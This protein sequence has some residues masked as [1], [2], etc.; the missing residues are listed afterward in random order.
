[1]KDFRILLVEGSPEEEE[2]IA[3]ISKREKYALHGS[4]SYR[5]AIDS[6]RDNDFDL[7]LIRCRQDPGAVQEVC[8]SIRGEAGEDPTQIIF[9]GDSD[10]HAE[11][12]FIECAHDFILVPV[13]E[14][15][16]AVR[17]RNAFNRYNQSRIILEELEFYRKAV[18][19]EE[20]LSSRILDRHIFLKETLTSMKTMN[21][22]LERSN[23]KLER[24]AKFDT[25]SGLLNRHALFGTMEIEVERAIRTG[26][27]LT[28]IM[29]DIDTF[30]QINDNYGHPVGDRVIEEI[31]NLIRKSLRKYDHAG[32]YGGEEF[33]I[34]LPN[35]TG[36]QAYAWAERFR[37]SLEA[38]T[39]THGKESILITA[40]LGVAQFRIGESREGW[41]SRADRAMYRAKDAGRN[42]TIIE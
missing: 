30:K 35:T 39:I 11:D 21:K 20:E 25:L 28:G 7:V 6:V 22:Q 15:E 23:K 12:S 37:E 3:R 9:I 24:I 8:S 27:P 41:V 36:Q 17:I 4:V 26:S 10:N 32:R 38:L 2:I 18:R 40:S 33:F 29:I 42:R 14:T 31:G 13:S 16:I 19:Q 1:M 34:I 5:R